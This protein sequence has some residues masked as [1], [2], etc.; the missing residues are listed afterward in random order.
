MDLIERTIQ[1]SWQHRVL[2]TDHVF[3][4]PNL[5]LRDNLSRDEQ[6]SLRRALV[7]VDEALATAQ[8]KLSAGVE[9]YFNADPTSATTRHQLSRL[10][11][12]TVLLAVLLSL[13]AAAIIIR[14]R[15]QRYKR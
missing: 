5:T 8:P 7:V 1:V 11:R 9:A 6:G 4:P 14:N 13:N 3:D 10:L 12:A 15:F 2:F